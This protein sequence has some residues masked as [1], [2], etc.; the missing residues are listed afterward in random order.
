[1]GAP[2]KTC[3]A[4]ARCRSLLFDTVYVFEEHATIAFLSGRCSILDIYMKGLLN[5]PVTYE[6]SVMKCHS[7]FVKGVI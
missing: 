2:C 7:F 3:I 6:T 1:M 5:N 4:F